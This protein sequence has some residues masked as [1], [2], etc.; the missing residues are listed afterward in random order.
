MVIFTGIFSQIVMPFVIFAYTVWLFV[1]FPIEYSVGLLLLVYFFYLLLL[2]V[3]YL[4]F[5]ACL[6]ERPREDLSRLC[7]LPLMPLFAF[8][9]RMNSLVAT[10]WE[11][12]A[13]GHKDTSMAPWWVTRKNKF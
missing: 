13:S 1:V 10:V 3:M 6:S 12:T 11:M 7:F 9:A 4:F 5:V 8:A 2:L